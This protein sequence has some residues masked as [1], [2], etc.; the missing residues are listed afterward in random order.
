MLIETI[1]KSEELGDFRCYFTYKESSTTKGTYAVRV[2]NL[3]TKKQMDYV[4]KTFKKVYI[5]FSFEK[6]G[7]ILDYDP[8]DFINQEFD[9]IRTY[10]DFYLLK[11]YNDN[12]RE[13][14][15]DLLKNEILYDNRIYL[16]T[17]QMGFIHYIKKTL[18][19]DEIVMPYLERKK[20]EI[21]SIE[22]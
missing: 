11:D 3:L 14:L 4:K 9:V 10:D 1:C 7:F 21:K 19:T 20:A 2:I 22:V 8:T 17:R 13:I 12:D 16:S 5:R 15:N 18:E 6:H